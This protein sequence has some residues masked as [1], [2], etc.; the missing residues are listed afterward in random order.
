MLGV[1]LCGGQSS[2]MGSDKGLLT[3]EAKTWAQ[4]AF[5]KMTGLG[6]TVKISVN[7]QQFP[8]YAA[9]FQPGDLVADNKSIALKGP[10]LGVL[11]AQLAFPNEDLFI[12]ACDML[13]M[14]TTILREIYIIYKNDPSH[15][16]YFYTNDGE[17]EPLCGIYTSTGLASIV[18]ML[19]SGQL[20]KHSM[21][22]MLDHLHKKVIP[23]H[24]DQKKYF[25]NFNAHSELNG[26]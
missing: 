20:S 18:S 25:R 17:P 6:I 10:L 24:V 21:K 3:L 7:E 12:L 1:I 8:E 13:L 2:R 16:A 22:F 23:L 5:E 11:S 14:E 19:R 4:T 26:L 15:E 9:V